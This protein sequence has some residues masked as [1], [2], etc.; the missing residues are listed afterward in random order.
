VALSRV[1]GLGVIELVLATDRP[2][3]DAVRERSG[4]NRWSGRGALR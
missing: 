2:I 1:I 4:G 3:G